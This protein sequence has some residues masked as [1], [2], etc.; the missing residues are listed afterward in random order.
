MMDDAKYLAVV[1]VLVELGKAA[2]T[3]P[4]QTVREIDNV[5]TVRKDGGK[6]PRC[7]VERR[8]FSDSR[9]RFTRA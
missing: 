8:E 9:R 2:N 3:D 4:A 1:E 5:L 7:E 6:Y